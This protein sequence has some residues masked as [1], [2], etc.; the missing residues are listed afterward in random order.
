MSDKHADRI[1]AKLMRLIEAAPADKRE[2][3]MQRIISDYLKGMSRPHIKAIRAR[4]VAEFSDHPAFAVVQQ[5]MDMID[6]QLA[7]REIA[8]RKHWR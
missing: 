1:V 2:D 8:G 6:G 7:L 4:M 5:T 3:R